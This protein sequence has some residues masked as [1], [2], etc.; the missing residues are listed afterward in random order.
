MWLEA[1]DDPKLIRL[2]LAERGAWWG[3]L[4]LAGKCAAGGKIVSGG[5]G[6]DMDEITDALHIKTAED[7]QSLESMIAKMEKR[8]SLIWNGNVLTVVHYE[9][10]QKVPPSARPEAVAE[11]VRRHR[12]RK[13]KAGKGEEVQPSPKASEEATGA[14]NKAGEA[15]LA[16]WSGVK[17][18][19]QDSNVATRFLNKL[20][21]EFPEVD[22]LGESKK[23]AA[24]KLSMPLM[25]RSMPFKQLWAWML[26]AREFAQKRRARDEQPGTHRQDDKEPSAARYREGLE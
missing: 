18:F 3:I 14:L 16:V 20:R 1:L 23:W 10:R 26:K 17:G 11:R 2:P 7:R 6:L 4:K 24:A 21:A 12:E 15:V 8:G 9:G 25:K 13:K 5:A 19:P 22:I